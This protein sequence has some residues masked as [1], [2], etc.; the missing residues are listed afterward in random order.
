MQQVGAPDTA[1]KAFPLLFLL[2]GHWL[3][4][5]RYKFVFD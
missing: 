2:V 3:Q 5:V 4:K 1:A